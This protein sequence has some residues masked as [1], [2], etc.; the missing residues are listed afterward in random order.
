[1]VI[2]PPRRTS[3]CSFSQQRRSANRVEPRVPQDGEAG[4]EALGESNVIRLPRDW[5]G[6]REE[7]VPFGISAATEEVADPDATGTLLASD[8]W[9]EES[10]AVQ[11]ALPAPAGC[12]GDEIGQHA[13]RLRVPLRAALVA[14]GAAALLGVGTVGLGLTG[15]SRPATTS[16]SAFQFGSLAVVLP[17]MLGIDAAKASSDRRVARL[18]AESVVRHPRRRPTR[19]ESASPARYVQASA[20]SLPTQGSAIAPREDTSATPSTTGAGT[21]VAGGP[22]V[23][24][25]GGGGGGA[26]AEGNSVTATDSHHSTAAGPVG[27]GAPF[28]PGHLG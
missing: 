12:S 13:R 9:G 5:L 25:G 23:G 4:R 6:P 2:I 10:A 15:S 18:R 7:L 17:P 3:T 22:S 8:F 20:S 26:G 21:G 27:P 1:M 16:S 19:D 24:G 14:A 11:H 28:G